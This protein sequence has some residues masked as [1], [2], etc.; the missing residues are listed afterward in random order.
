MILISVFV[1]SWFWEIEIK[2][3]RI[4][5]E[6]EPGDSTITPT[7]L[8]LTQ[9]TLVTNFVNRSTGKVERV[10]YNHTL[11]FY[12]RTLKP[13]SFPR[14]IFRK[15]FSS[16]RWPGSLLRAD[17]TTVYLPE[18]VSLLWL[19]YAGTKSIMGNKTL[20]LV[21]SSGNLIPLLPHSGSVIPKRKEVLDSFKIPT[22]LTN[23]GKYRLML[24]NSNEEVLSFE[25]R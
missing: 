8:Q 16:S 11:S 2:M 12:S 15:T 19:G 1:A 4:G 10:T 24:T 3:P 13:E 21:P 14:Y 20:A 7:F 5:L 18:N 17:E 22:L 9:G 6:Y 23:K 25:I